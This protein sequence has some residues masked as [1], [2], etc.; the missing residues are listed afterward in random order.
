MARFSSQATPELERIVR[1]CLE[2]E[3]EQRYQSAQELS[4]DLRHLRREQQGGTRRGGPSEPVQ[5]FARKH[6]DRTGH[7]CLHRVGKRC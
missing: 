7:P 6:P 2:K 4:I 5:A 3:P 1:K